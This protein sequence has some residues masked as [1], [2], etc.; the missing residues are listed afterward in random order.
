MEIKRII[1]GTK[2]LCFEVLSESLLFDINNSSEKDIVLSDIKPGYSYTKN[3]QNK[4]GNKG[5]VRVEIKTFTPNSKYE[6][7]FDTNQGCNTLSYQLNDYDAEHFEL[8]YSENFT[9]EKSMNTMNFKF[10]SKLYERGNKKKINATLD[11]LENIIVAKMKE[12]S[13]CQD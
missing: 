2:E 11:Q 8:I 10:M 6:V 7:T 3:L 13:V 9:S 4:V 1:K 5:A 12:N